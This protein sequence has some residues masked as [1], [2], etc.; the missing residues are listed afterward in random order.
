M[1]TVAATMPNLLLEELQTSLSMAVAKVATC[2]HIK[3]NAILA[4]STISIVKNNLTHDHLS[5]SLQQLIKAHT[6][7]LIDSHHFNAG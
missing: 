3:H 1:L 7:N 6:V 5:V 4:N 2:N